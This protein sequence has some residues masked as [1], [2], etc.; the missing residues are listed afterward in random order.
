MPT[1]QSIADRSMAAGLKAIRGLASSELVDRLGLRPTAE[2]LLYG[3]ARTT[4]RTA[5]G[6]GRTFSAASRLA[7]PVRQKP[8]GP[9]ALFDLTPTEEQAL[10]RDSVRDFALA[11]IRPA[12]PAAD[13][14]CQTPEELLQATA[15]LGLTAMGVPEALGGAMEERSAVTATLAAE[16]LAQGD[17]GV[18]VACLAPGAVAGAIALWGDASQQ[19]TYL[20]ELVGDRPPAAALALMEPQPLF[21][22]FALRAQA[23]RLPQGGFRIDAV[24]SM[25]PRASVGELFVV[26]AQLDGA[27]GL[28]IIESAT[29]GLSVQAE[30]AMGVRAAATG[31]LM[32]EDALLGAGA[33]LG[34]GDPGAYAQCV[35]L[36]RIGW[37]ALALGT[38]RALLDYVG[39]YVNERIA[40]G[41]PISHRQAVAFAVANIAIELEG[42]RLATYRAA[43]RADQGLAFAREA[44]LARRLCAEHGARIGSDGV[45]LLGGHGYTKE[46][47]VERWYRDLRAAGLMEGTLIV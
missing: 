8:A 24:K 41:E 15:E 12:A 31:R 27:P 42:M 46:H 35:S 2:R 3:A 9:A 44:A 26:A 5:A 19:A 4:T 18:A 21:D 22:P 20:H 39:P 43:S 33:L 25:V 6:A 1:E 16:A 47:P 11:R 14:A 34:G 32:L 37:C 7:R 29:R 23:R 45:Q 28:F 10:L 17:M 13:A 38:A 30:P 36:A 40:F